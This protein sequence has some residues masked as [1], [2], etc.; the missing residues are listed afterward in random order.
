[1]QGRRITSKG[2][3]IVDSESDL[4]ITV[5]D[6]ALAP[7]ALAEVDVGGGSEEPLTLRDIFSDFVVYDFDDRAMSTPSLRRA[8]SRLRE[9]GGNLALALAGLHEVGLLDQL[10]DDAAG[11]LP[12]L[13]GLRW[14]R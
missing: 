5:M 3:Q 6:D 9:D 13:R 12:G 2:R 7:A 4:K 14:W 8:G 1:M 11:I 10:I